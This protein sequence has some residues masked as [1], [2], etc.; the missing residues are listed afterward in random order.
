M[1]NVT[2]SRFQDELTRQAKDAGKLPASFD[3]PKAH[4]ENYP[5][6][7]AGVLRPARQEGLLPLFPFGSDFTDV[8]QR[9]IPA[10]Q[11]LQDAQR[12][13]RLLPGLL[14]QGF[15]RQPDAADAECLARLGLDKP[16]TWPERAYRA[17]VNAAL[18]KSRE[19]LK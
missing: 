13:P 15:T 16:T 5:D 12:S 2:D 3:I 1:L 8:E 17:L 14:W 10:L 18:M 11:F 4:R 19:G 9:L 6:R 7:I